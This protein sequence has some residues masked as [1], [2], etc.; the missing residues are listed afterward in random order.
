MNT[1]IRVLVAVAAASVASVC[2]AQDEAP[3]V[4]VPQVQATP[5]GEEIGLASLEERLKQT[6]AISPLKKLGLKGE[7]DNL[8]A[9][10]RIAHAGGQ[11]DLIALRDPYDKLILK[12]RGML[13]RDPQ[14]ARDIVA[15]KDAIWD[16]LADRTQFA[17]L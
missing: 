12:I 1:Q 13:T 11:P 10:F 4:V 9:K 5:S 3:A 14:L 15:S 6:K 16:R 8:L 7:I 2:M 17:S